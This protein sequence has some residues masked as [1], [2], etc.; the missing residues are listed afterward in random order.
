MYIHAD[1]RILDT[2]MQSFPFESRIEN[3][4]HNSKPD[5]EFQ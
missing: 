3:A 1:T 5:L 4:I 2:L